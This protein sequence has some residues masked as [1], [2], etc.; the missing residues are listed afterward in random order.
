MWWDY[1][2]LSVTQFSLRNHSIS[3]VCVDLTVSTIIF[4]SLPFNEEIPCARHYD[5]CLGYIITIAH[6]TL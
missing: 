4:G 3:D 6:I 5:K 2:L 1:G